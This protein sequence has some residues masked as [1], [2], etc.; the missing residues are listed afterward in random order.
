MCAFS[1]GFEENQ[2]EIAAYRGAIA[3]SESM[4]ADTF[5]WSYMSAKITSGS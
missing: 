5:L 1:A 3:I 2:G 4:R